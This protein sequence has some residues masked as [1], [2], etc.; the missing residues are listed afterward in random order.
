M[1]RFHTLTVRDIRRETENCVSVAFTVPEAL[2]T[3]FRFLPGQHL[4]LRTMVQGERI[5]R[6]YSIC[7]TPEDPELRIA[8][9]KIPN[10]KFSSYANADLQVGMQL[11]S[12]PPAGHFHPPR[13]VAKAPHYL[14]F[15]AG[16]GITPVFSILRS[17]LEQQP[18]SA[19]TLIY[20]NQTSASTIFLSELAALKNRYMER[21][22]LLTLFSREETDIPL[23]SGRFTDEKCL[24][25]FSR[26]VRIQDIHRFFLCGPWELLDLVTDTLVGLGVGKDR[27]HREVF[28]P[29]DTSAPS[30]PERRPSAVDPKTAGELDITLDGKTHHLAFDP[31][32]SATILEWAHQ[33]GLELPFAC[34]AGVCA[35]CRAKI[36][37]G[38]VRMSTN[39]GLTPEEVAQ[40]YV[41]TCQSVAESSALHV[42]FDE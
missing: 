23:L 9:K 34:K 31:T 33:F 1:P 13:E 38:H 2:Q 30:S 7:S 16:S 28:A 15:A 12:M 25:V 27:I 18:D 20:L 22:H 40:G 42:N 24:A 36:G 6:N 32:A 37:R 41:L 26:L 10:G 35:T 29:P 11:E 3:T 14:G 39:Y 4:A 21:F 17:V 8:I 5:I 19:F